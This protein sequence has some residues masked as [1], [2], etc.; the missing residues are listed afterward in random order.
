MTWTEMNG[1]GLGR[2]DE[3]WNEGWRLRVSVKER[4]RLSFERIREVHEGRLGRSRDEEKTER[5]D[6]RAVRRGQ[7]KSFFRGDLSFEHHRF[8]RKVSVL[9]RLFEQGLFSFLLHLR[10]QTKEEVLRSHEDLGGCL[11]AW[12]RRSTQVDDTAGQGSHASEGRRGWA[13]S[14]GMKE[15]W[16]CWGVR[17]RKPVRCLFSELEQ[18]SCDT[19]CGAV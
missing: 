18:P 10:E 17:R 19:G 11:G 7:K 12:M 8:K 2:R 6:C 1:V 5:P 4:G 14:Q 16:R 9:K 3:E 15:S 13:E